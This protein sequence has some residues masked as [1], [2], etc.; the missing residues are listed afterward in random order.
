[1]TFSELIGFN[2]SYIS[3]MKSS[4][5]LPSRKA[6]KKICEYLNISEER[7]REGMEENDAVSV[8]LYGE[9]KRLSKGLSDEEATFLIR[10][11]QATK[12]EDAKAYIA[13]LKRLGLS[14][15]DAH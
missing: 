5:L 9:M 14:F 8:S 6:M 12:P 4:G 1:M 13:H 11:L 10:L 15:P 7:F 2:R 3:S